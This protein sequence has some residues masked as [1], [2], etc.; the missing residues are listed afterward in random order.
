MYLFTIKE[1]DKI[2]VWNLVPKLDEIKKYKEKEL[3]KVKVDKQIISHVAVRHGKRLNSS[4]SAV[5]CP[6]YDLSVDLEGIGCSDMFSYKAV[7]EETEEYYNAFINS[8]PELMEQ[9]K[10]FRIVGLNESNVPVSNLYLFGIGNYHERY[11]DAELSGL[12]NLPRSIYILTA[13]QVGRIDLVKGLDASE[14]LAL[15]DIEYV[16]E[17]DVNNMADLIK[18][19]LVPNEVI[20]N[21]RK[22]LDDSHYVM[23]LKKK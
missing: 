14:Q 10:L 5:T 15:F 20:E 12:I 22:K 23:S 3:K 4:Y 18:Y 19:G 21:T 13:L 11:R 9:T 7:N 17:I 2:E 6:H 16:Q 1:N 8:D